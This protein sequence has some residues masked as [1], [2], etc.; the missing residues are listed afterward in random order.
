MHR[1][2]SNSTDPIAD[3]LVA[4]LVMMILVIIFAGCFQVE[5]GAFTDAVRVG[6]S[7]RVE[8]NTVDVAVAD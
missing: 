5:S 7:V 8:S 3:L 6:V 1:K 2:R 4:V